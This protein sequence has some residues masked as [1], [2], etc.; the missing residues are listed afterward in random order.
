MYIPM[1]YFYYKNI[2]TACSLF[3]STQP[4]VVQQPVP[5]IATQMND[6]ALI[7]IKIC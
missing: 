3:L 6:K 7:T 4:D 2:Y 5:L 1:V